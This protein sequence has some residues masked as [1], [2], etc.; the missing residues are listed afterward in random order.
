MTL[1]RTAVECPKVRRFQLIHC[2]TSWS[3]KS[4]RRAP[5]GGAIL[6]VVCV[7]N[8]EFVDG[9]F[10]NGVDRVFFC[11]QGEHH[12]HE[13]ATVIE[14]VEGYTVGCPMLCLYAWAN[15]GSFAINRMVSSISTTER[16]GF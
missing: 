12:L 13:V 15:V 10:H 7:Q 16:L 8:Q 9:S 6:F 3:V 4:P 2:C 5:Q 11:G 1:C 14:V